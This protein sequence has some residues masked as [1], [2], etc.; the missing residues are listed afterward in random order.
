[1]KCASIPGKW[2]EWAPW[3]RMDARLL[4]AVHAEVAKQGIDPADEVRVREVMSK[5][6]GRRLLSR[7]AK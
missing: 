6:K 5:L 7:S 3:H 4:L 1:M 2:I